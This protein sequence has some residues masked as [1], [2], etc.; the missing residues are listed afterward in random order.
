[1]K[2]VTIK[3]TTENHSIHLDTRLSSDE[4]IDFAWITGDID[5]KRPLGS[6]NFNVLNQVEYKANK[7]A[8]KAAYADFRDLLDSYTDDF[9]GTITEEEVIDDGENDA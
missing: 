5:A 1:M 2:K 8:A 6:T 4:G 9:V 7:A 3:K